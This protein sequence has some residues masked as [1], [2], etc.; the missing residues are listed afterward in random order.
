MGRLIKENLE[1]ILQDITG[2]KRST[3]KNIE[4]WVNDGLNRLC[5]ET[6]LAS[7]MRL[8]PEDDG[9]RLTATVT[10]SWELRWWILSPA[11]SI[12]I[13]QMLGHLP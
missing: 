5:A 2:S 7:D 10:D 3:R 9:V 4:A 13:N 12:Q 6:R 8:P 11:V 1:A